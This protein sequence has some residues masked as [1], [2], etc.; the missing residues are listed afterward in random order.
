MKSRYP[1]RM[2][3]FDLPP[4]LLTDDALSFAP[5][6]DAFLLVLREGKT[7]R[8]QLEHA[9]E[10]LQ[11]VPI[12]GTTLNAAENTSMPYYYQR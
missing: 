9:M 12:L 10:L 8:Q 2:V 6:V 11:D 1:S 4:V 3:L 5:H 7:D